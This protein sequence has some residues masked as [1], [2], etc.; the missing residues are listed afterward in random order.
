MID[1]ST[2]MTEIYSIFI[3]TLNFRQFS[4]WQ[5]NCQGFNE[6]TVNEK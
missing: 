2:D 1:K 3:N 5:A 6:G 4:K